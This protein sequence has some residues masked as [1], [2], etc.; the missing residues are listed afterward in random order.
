MYSHRA[1]P[2]RYRS[3]YEVGR[4]YELSCKERLEKEGYV[5]LR[6][7]A[8]RGFADLIAIRQVDGT[9][10][11]DLKQRIRFIQCKTGKMSRR[12][13]ERIKELEE[14]LGIKIE[15]W[16]RRWPSRRALYWRFSRARN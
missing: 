14:R 1:I 13:Y 3:S 16:T 5:V 12:Q 7:E 15:V 10:E 9:G 6:T 2:Q 11:A 8:S 4:R